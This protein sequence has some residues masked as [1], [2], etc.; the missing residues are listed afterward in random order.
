MDWETQLI[1]IYVTLSDLLDNANLNPIVR[2]SNNYSKDMS[3]SEILSVYIY[4]IQQG[5]RNQKQIHRH[6]RNHLLAYFPG[7]LKYKQFNRRLNQAASQLAV[8]LEQQTDNQ[9]PD[10]MLLDSMPIVLSK[11]FKKERIRNC[12]LYADVGHCET[13]KMKYYGV[14]LHIL[15]ERQSDSL[16][17]PVFIDISPASMHDLPVFR[18]LYPNLADVDIY[19]DKA[20]RDNEMQWELLNNQL[21]NIFNPIKKEKNKELEYFDGIY[22]NL[23][24]SVRQNIESFFAWII[25]KTD[26]QDASKVRSP[27]GILLHVYGRMVASL[28]L[29]QWKICDNA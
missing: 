17:Y 16:P 10:S 18:Q 20:Y 9:I 23:V 6:T 5:L 8:I 19:M 21:V 12:D 7:L 26:I 29:Y 4:G 2:L 15:A 27:G 11:N 14:K 3:D 24:S 25:E 22:N 1:T 28:F 13:K